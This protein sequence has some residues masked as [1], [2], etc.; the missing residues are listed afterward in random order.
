[1]STKTHLCKGEGMMCQTQK[2]QCCPGYECKGVQPE[3]SHAV[4][5]PTEKRTDVGKAC[6]S[7]DDCITG[8]C[9]KQDCDKMKSVVRAS[10]EDMR[11]RCAWYDSVSN[12]ADFEK[13]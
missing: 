12:P 9:K 2:R 6:Y 10:C 11:G 1:M 13:S 7:S 8:F 3:S 5:V 4:C